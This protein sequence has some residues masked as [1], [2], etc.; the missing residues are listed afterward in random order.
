MGVVEVYRNL[1][2]K[3]LWFSFRSL[4]T[5]RV[6]DR[7]D[8]KAGDTACLRNVIFKVSEAGRKRVLREKRKNV[9]ALIRGEPWPMPNIEIFRH[10]YSH[11][12]PVKVKY[13]PYKAPHFIGTTPGTKNE[14][15]LKE[16]EYV[17]FDEDGVTAWTK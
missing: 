10:R 2:R 17:T 12:T 15:V 5:R 7:I 6:I 9:H 11:L 3:G 8:L 13:D 14:V 16:A 1:N 4:D